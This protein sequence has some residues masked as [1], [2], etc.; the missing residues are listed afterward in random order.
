MQL[1]IMPPV[2]PMRK[3]PGLIPPT[4]AGPITTTFF[5]RASFTSSRVLFSGTPYE[6]LAEVIAE[7]DVDRDLGVYLGCISASPRR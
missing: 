6:T 1:S 4:V 5:S 3:Q 7:V 2:L